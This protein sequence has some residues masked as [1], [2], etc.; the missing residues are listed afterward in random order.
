MADRESLDRESKISR[1]F[2]TALHLTGNVKPVT[3]DNKPLL[4][5]PRGT[6]N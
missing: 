1:P 2:Q 3:D 5:G 6:G 4:R